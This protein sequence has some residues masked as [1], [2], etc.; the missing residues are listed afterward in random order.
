MTK[1]K[2]IF[3]LGNPGDKYEYT[4]HNVG[5]LF[6]EYLA[7]EYG[8]K[9]V[10]KSGFIY[11]EAVIGGRKMML[12]KADESEI[13]MNEIGIHLKAAMKK[14]NV[15]KS[16]IL[17]VHDDSDLALGKY[18]HSLDVSSAGHKGVQSIIDVLKTQNFHRIRIGIRTRPGKALDFV[19][20]N[21]S[22]KDREIFYK[23]FEE[24][25][26]YLEKKIEEG[27]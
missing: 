11:Y 4:N 23:V 9:E 14:F 19:L 12:M 17:T 18:K 6:I 5:T 7:G 22:K 24:I 15:L 25:K 16:E 10:K 1:I 27:T 8:A 13:F 26:V 20:K 3:G 2:I 21:I